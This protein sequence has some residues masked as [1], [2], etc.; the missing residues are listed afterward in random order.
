MK[1][2]KVNVNINVT[3]TDENGNQLVVIS[4]NGDVTKS[5]VEEGKSYAISIKKTVEVEQTDGV[6]AAVKELLGLY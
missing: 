1:E 5:E 4:V 6:I 3:D 2:E